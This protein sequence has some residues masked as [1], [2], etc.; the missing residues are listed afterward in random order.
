MDET[1]SLSEKEL[2]QQ[3]E[4]LKEFEKELMV[5]LDGL[6]TNLPELYQGYANLVRETF[7]A[8]FDIISVSSYKSQKI[9]LAVEV[10]AR[11]IEAYGA[12]KAAREHNK[13]L[14]KYLKI[15]Q[16][17][18]SL[19]KSKI[20]RLKREI[21]RKLPGSERLFDKFTSMNFDLSDKPK[22]LIIRQA[23][24]SLRYLTLY[25]TNLFLLALSEYLTK[26]FEAWSYGNQT[27]GVQKPDYYSVNAHLLDELYG[28]ED[29][30]ET[31]EALCDQ[32]GRFTGADIILLSDPQLCIYSLQNVLCEIDMS[33]ASPV[34]RTL[35]SNNPG[36]K[37]YTRVTKDVRDH[38]KDN[39][40]AKVW[41]ACIIGA[42]IT[43]LF[44]IFYFPAEGYKW[45][46]LGIA[47]AAILRI[48]IKNSKNA[49][50]K[51]I[52]DG[53]Q[54]TDETDA[55]ILQLCGYVEVKEID[56]ERKNTT[57]ALIKGFFNM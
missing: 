41:L 44:I 24:L 26:E 22:D 20:N 7:T 48:G 30:F 16:E 12:F 39:P 8:A 17:Y 5:Q 4:V 56:Y 2:L 9:V 1:N 3:S 38:I 57:S 43:T 14:D 15:K 31:I 25:R 51:H 28:V 10:L 46:V 32:Q 49:K 52:I 47:L 55:S 18:A 21:E 36:F 29:G 33:A 27:S 11:G 35:I 54:K 53:E 40:G 37:H 45:W 6:A 19:N 34:V 42:I 50:I 23:N 13:R